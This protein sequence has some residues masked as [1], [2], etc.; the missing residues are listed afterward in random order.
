MQPGRQAGR[1]GVPV[2]DV[3]GGRVLAE[4]VVVDP[5]VPHQVVGTQPGEHLGQVAAVEVAGPLRA[6]AGGFDRRLRRQHPDLGLLGG[7]EPGDQEGGGVD[8]RFAGRRQVPEQAGHGDGAGAHA[9]HVG[10]GAAGDLAGDL[11]RLLAGGH[12][13]VEV[14]VALGRR[15]VAPADREVR[16]AGVDHVL[17][18][19]APGADVGDVELVDLRR[20]GDERPGEGRLAGRRVLDQLEHLAAVHDLARGDGEVAAHGERTGV[21]RR[22]HAAVVAEV[23]SH[24]PHAR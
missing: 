2:Q 20:D 14:P 10:V 18:Q 13:G 4:Q 22:R 6:G 24:V 8:D 9:D 3:E 11:D 7:V 16:H 15:R 5:V 12:V 1:V 19:A 21:D 23:V 17:D